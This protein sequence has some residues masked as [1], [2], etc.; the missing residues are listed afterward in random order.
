MT[1]ERQKTPQKLLKKR[2]GNKKEAKTQQKASKGPK[3][4][5][6]DGEKHVSIKT[7]KDDVKKWKV[8]KK[9]KKG[10]TKWMTKKM[11]QERHKKSYKKS[12][13]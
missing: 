9:R 4:L 6:Q 11:I 7:T 13:T 12:K 3:K 1:K 2:E 8:K 10:D 5:R